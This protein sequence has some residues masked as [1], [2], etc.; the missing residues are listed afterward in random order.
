MVHLRAFFFVET[1]G[2][3]DKCRVRLTDLGVGIKATEL[4]V[5]RQGDRRGDKNSPRATS[6]IGTSAREGEVAS[7][8]MLRRDS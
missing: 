6:M 3:S 8:L 7:R 1:L 5:S 4:L 2:V